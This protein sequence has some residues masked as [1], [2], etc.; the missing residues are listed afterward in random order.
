MMYD[1]WSGLKRGYVSH[2][3]CLDWLER[4]PSRILD[5]STKTPRPRL[6]SFSLTASELFLTI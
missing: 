5:I 4:T 3:I 6:P 1:E 2:Y